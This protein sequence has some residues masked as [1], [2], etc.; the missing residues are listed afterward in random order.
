[1]KFNELK[2]GQRV[3]IRAY[4]KSGEATFWS[5]VIGSDELNT[6]IRGLSR[7]GSLITFPS[8]KISVEIVAISDGEKYIWD[9]VEMKV[10]KRE[11]GRCYSVD[12]VRKAKSQEVKKKQ[13]MTFYTKE[14]TIAYKDKEGVD[15]P[16]P[17]ITRFLS[18][19]KIEIMSDDKGEVNDLGTISISMDESAPISIDVKI[20]KKADG[21]KEGNVQLYIYECALMKPSQPYFTLIDTL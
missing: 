21:D 10:T 17:G 14:C 11:G 20:L 6:Y 7:D 8:D 9:K 3:K 12:S 2:K 19:S 4:N 5:S 16:V 13:K 18:R 15:E 1:M